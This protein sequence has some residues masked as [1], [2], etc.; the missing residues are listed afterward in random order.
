ML[1][2]PSTQ[3]AGLLH[4]PRSAG[5]RL[6]SVVSHGDERA[7][8]PFLWRLCTALA[9]LGYPV[10][11]LDATQS[12]SAGNPG[13]EQWLELRGRHSDRAC[14]PADWTVI[15]SGLGLAHVCNLPYNRAAKHQVLG[16]LF[17]HQAIV[18]LYANA[19]IQVQLLG[20]TPIQPILATSAEKS[21][22]LTSYL[23][24][25][26]L[27]VSGHL[28]PTILNMMPVPVSTGRRAAAS[29]NTNLELCAKSFLGFDVNSIYL[30][31]L[32]DERALYK[33]V[34]LLATRM[35]DGSLPLLSR[36]EK[37]VALQPA[38]GASAWSGRH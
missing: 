31:P 34:R 37:A 5:P 32:S 29:A 23:A 10:W 3:A 18:V 28:E 27:W 22:L 30:D 16:Q 14:G 26:R 24:L 8:L 1:D 2:L 15:P 21:A 13:L 4:L 12:E 6:L 35:V 38:T 19:L 11:V 17:D 20:D 9:E 7:E 25:K 36:P 33:T